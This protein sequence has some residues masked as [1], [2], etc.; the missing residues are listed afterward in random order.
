MSLIEL[1][2]VKDG[3]L[4]V[5]MI[6]SRGDGVLVEY[7]ELRYEDWPSSSGRLSTLLLSRLLNR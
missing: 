1:V 7:L 4:N 6:I 5:R 2:M 3:L